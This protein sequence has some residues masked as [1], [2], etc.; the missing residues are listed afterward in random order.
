M[1]LVD[2]GRGRSEYGPRMRFFLS[3]LGSLAVSV[4]LAA[5]AQPE[6]TT[7]A[8]GLK[9][10][11]TVH[12]TGA[13]PRPGQVV[14]ALY[15]GTLPDGTVFDR[16]EKRD[17]PFAFTLG[18]KQVIKGWDEGFALMHVGDH[19][20]L[21]VP[22]TLA[23]G[24]RQRGSIP[25]NSTLKFDVELVG[26]KDRSL[27]DVLT[28]TLGIAGLAEAQKQF[29]ELKAANFGDC[30]VS[31][32]QLNLLG[33]RYLQK[34]KLPE[35]MAIFQWNVELNPTSGN[36]YDSLGEAY[37]KAGDR[38]LAL[39]NYAKSLELDPTN[40]NAER[41][42]AALKATPDTPGALAG[43]QAKMQLDDEFNAAD[44]ALT[45][46]KPV[47][48]LPLR[49]KLDAFLKA[50]PSAESAAGLVRDYFYLVESIDLKQ[51]AAEWRSFLAS[52]NAAIKEMA[53]KKMELAALMEHP[54]ELTYAAVDGRTVDLTKWRGK[55]VLI[56]FWATWCG[57]CL[58]ELPNVKAV[59]QKYHEQGFEIAGVSFDQAHDTAHPA[60]RQKS[61]DEFKAF[62]VEHEM[63]WPQYY[64]GTYWMNPLGK[65]YGIRAIPAM[66]LL[67]KEGRLV[68]TNARGPK[69]EQEVKRLLEAK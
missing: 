63:P 41:M 55:V 29:A 21:L 28:E 50:Y 67:D 8:S 6:F 1:L 43:M 13:Q 36:V 22:P 25:P 56:D 39:K 9:Y 44:E 60:K 31:E 24:D 20:T 19:A 47:S 62:T 34:N 37:I 48:V 26:L 42:L 30:Y 46:G 10:A 27:A 12:G 23:Y 54:M 58:Q 15:A 52:E 7:T 38:A 51:A 4:A 5:D 61:A 64:D 66:F 3:L 57:P 53:K 14:L 68:S 16:N 35:A 17:Q 49:A 45:A 65:K 69:L 11:I 2:C 33:Y 59:Y 32:G 18:Q 40:K